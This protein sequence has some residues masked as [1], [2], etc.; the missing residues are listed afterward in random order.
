MNEIII[1]LLGI[2]KVI[3]F[4]VLGCASIFSLFL[5]IQL[6]SFR[7]FKFNL[8]KWLCYNLINKYM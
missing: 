5:I 7:I 2:V 1:V 8:Y 3:K 6:I 4:F